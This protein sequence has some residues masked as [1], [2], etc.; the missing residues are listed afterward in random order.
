MHLRRLL[1]AVVSL[2]P[3][4]S[5]FSVPINVLSAARHIAIY[6]DASAFPEE[7]SFYR[8]SGPSAPLADF[9]LEIHDKVSVLGPNDEPGFEAY[10]VSAMAES[11]AQQ[12]SFVRFDEIFFDTFVLAETSSFTAFEGYS[13]AWAE[14]YFQAVFKVPFAARYTIDYGWSEIQHDL[15]FTSSRSGEL[16]TGNLDFLPDSGI[17]VPGDTYTLT[18]YAYAETWFGGDIGRDESG[19]IFADL[20]VGPQVPETGATLSLLILSIAALAVLRRAHW[21]CSVARR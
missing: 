9:S 2:L 14:T 3:A 8:A 21:L 12:T 11:R 19:F 15:E 7:A 16:L 10:P 5:A 13:H 1:V 20:K 18:G 4:S 17:L 6:G